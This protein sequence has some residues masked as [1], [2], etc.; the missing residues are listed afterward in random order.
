MGRD[1]QFG[2]PDAMR[3]LAERNVDQARQAYDQL[4]DVARQAQDMVSNSQEAMTAGALEIQEKAMKYAETNMSAS[5]E[6]AS[7]LAQVSDMQ[8]ALKLQ[9]EFAHRQMQTYA[10]QAQELTRLMAE[11]PQKAQP[12]R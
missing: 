7:R 6:F 5:F 10:E 4:M 8:A 3:E 11:A 12:K 9:Q 2:I 1:Q